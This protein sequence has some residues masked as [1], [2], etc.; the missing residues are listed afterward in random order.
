MPD[1]VIT[2]WAV[3]LAIVVT[4][5]HVTPRTVSIHVRPSS[6]PDRRSGGMRL[7]QLVGRTAATTLVVGALLAMA[8]AA[9]ALNSV[10]EVASP[11]TT[12]HLVVAFGDSV[13]AGAA[14]A[15]SPFP[16]IYG[17][18]LRHRTGE[19]VSVANY[20]VT[21]LDSAGL[22][23]ELH[24][25]KVVEAVRSADVVLVTIGANDFTDHHEQVVEGVCAT[26]GE[27]DCVSDAMGSLRA[28]LATVLDKIRELRRGK[29]TSVL[30][31]GYWNV[32]EDGNVAERASGTAGLRASLDLTRRVNA[33]ISSVSLFAGAHYVDLFGPFQHRDG[34][35]DSLMA[36]DGD[37]P[38][39][40][41]HQLIAKTMLAAGLPHIS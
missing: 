35:I 14:C 30:V 32:F 13:P 24:Q 5:G 15:C 40:A 16:E 11:G 3:P 6:S 25:P 29:S 23:E 31:S 8:G 12:R 17:G 4:L 21:G 36:S 18:L 28:N 19:S 34:D 22:L 20:A 10:A 39:A 33:A 7:G 37:H 38:N 27:V 26:S 9:P 1:T 2:G 41:G